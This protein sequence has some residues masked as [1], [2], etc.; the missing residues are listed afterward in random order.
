MVHMNSN[1]LVQGSEIRDVGLNPARLRTSF[2]ILDK[3]TY[4]Q[5]ANM[6]LT[7]LLSISYQSLFT[8]RD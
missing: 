4:Y 1:T 6:L 5:T 3:I 2:G 8:N 7:K